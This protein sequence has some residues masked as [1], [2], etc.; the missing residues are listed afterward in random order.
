M[1]MEIESI[2]VKAANDVD[3][4]Y[5][6]RRCTENGMMIVCVDAL[7]KSPA[8]VAKLAGQS[9]LDGFDELQEITEEI[10]LQY[11]QRGHATVKTEYP[12]E[13]AAM[14]AITLL[15]VNNQ[16]IGIVQKGSTQLFWIR[17]GELCYQSVSEAVSNDAKIQMFDNHLQDG[18]ALLLTTDGLW[19]PIREQEIV[20]DYMKSETAKQWISYLLTRKGLIMDEE[21][22]CY[23]AMAIMVHQSDSQ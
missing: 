20:I 15:V 14:M 1:I 22:D 9:I 19:M 11:V 23:S 10:L 21:S 17:E 7:Q 8:G 4:D 12:E 6:G 16:K 18:D 5:V 13:V 2:S 3:T